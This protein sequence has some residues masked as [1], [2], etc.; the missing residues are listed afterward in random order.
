VLLAGAFI[1]AAL[2]IVAF[3]G[4]IGWIIV[5]LTGYACA[6]LVVIW[7]WIYKAVNL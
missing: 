2:A 1:A 5:G 7:I 6:L 3:S 4:T